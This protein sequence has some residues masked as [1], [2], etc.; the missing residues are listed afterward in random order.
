MFHV[1]DSV[2]RI[3][4]DGRF[5]EWD[6]PLGLFWVPARDNM[7][8][9]PLLAEQEMRIYGPIQKGESVLD[10]GANIGDFTR[11]ALT[12]GAGLVVSIEISP[13]TIEC[14]RRNFKSEI[15]AGRV[16]LVTDGVWDRDATMKLYTSKVMGS[17][18]DTVTNHDESTNEGPEVSLTT[19][20]KI[21]ER[22]HLSKVDVIKLDVEGA[23][24]RGLAGAGETIRKHHPRIAFDSETFTPADVRQ[25]Q[26]ELDSIAPGYRPLAS[27]IDLRTSIRADVIR[28]EH[29][30]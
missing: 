30:P 22:L 2:R 17:G 5:V 16:I 24:F 28:F 11:S 9:V 26:A 1:R 23:E 6:T 18:V 27:C 19:I 14:L 7:G 12:D 8:F 15:A 13:D 10:C 20:D 4:T 3:S 29:R 21:V 25:I